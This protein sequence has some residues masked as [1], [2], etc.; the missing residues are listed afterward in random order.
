MEHKCIHGGKFNSEIGYPC[1][2]YTWCDV[3]REQETCSD[4][5]AIPEPEKKDKDADGGLY[6][7]VTGT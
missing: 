2:L 4:F 3:I 1:D 7:P 5:E 6:L